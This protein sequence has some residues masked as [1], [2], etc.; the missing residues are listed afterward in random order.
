MP[1]QMKQSKVPARQQALAAQKQARAARRAPHEEQQVLA[2]KTL[3]RAARRA[4][5]EELT[6]EER[7]AA[8]KQQERTDTGKPKSSV[9]IY[10]PLILQYQ[11]D[12]T[13]TLKDVIFMQ[14][15]G[16]HHERKDAIEEMHKIIG[17]LRNQAPPVHNLSNIQDFMEITRWT[18]VFPGKTNLCLRQ[19]LRGIQSTYC[20]HYG[21]HYGKGD[22]STENA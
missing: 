18:E 7:Q 6:D 8:A 20:K 22:L 10:Q 14:C 13:E 2:A 12:P 1:K 16:K 5:R 21:E 17:I 15:I 4:R 3:A 11:Q 9:R 19:T